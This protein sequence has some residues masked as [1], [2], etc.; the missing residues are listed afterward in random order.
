MRARL[1][2]LLIFLLCLGGF[3]LSTWAMS[4]RI[5]DFNKHAGFVRFHAEPVVS[6]EFRLDGW[7]EGALK[8]KVDELGRSFLELTYAGKQTLIPVKTPPAR[9]LPNL[10]GYDEWVKVLAF[11][12]VAAGPDGKSVAVPGTTRLWV[13]T[14]NTPSGYDPNAWGSVRKSEWVFNFHELMQ[15]GTVRIEQRRWPRGYRGEK[16]LQS[17]AAEAQKAVAEKIAPTVEQARAAELA[18][19]QPLK[20][21][22]PEYFAALHV[23]PKINVPQYKFEDTALQFSVLG[24]TIPVAGFSMLGAIL[25]LGFALAPRV[26][27]PDEQPSSSL[28]ASPS[29]P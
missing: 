16:T 8:D 24:W 11:N 23:I 19:I 21:R 10:A 2:A 27:R 7:P 1:L 22:S 26:K 6:R 25:S 13:V 9:D 14:R 18:A 3:A 12:E 15:D 20:E 5:A 28:Q 17:F 4:A 29:S